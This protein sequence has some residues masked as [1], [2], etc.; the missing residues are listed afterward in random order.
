MAIFAVFI[1]GMF[2][3]PALW[4]RLKGNASEPMTKG[5]FEAKG[6][7]THTGHCSAR[8]AKIQMLI[9]PVLILVWGCAIITIVALV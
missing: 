4:T 8:D 6:I 5:E 3:V 7:M 2:G 1:A 9:L